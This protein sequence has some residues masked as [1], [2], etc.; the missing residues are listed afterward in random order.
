M[1][2]LLVQLKLYSY[3]VFTVQVEIWCLENT[4]LCWLSSQAIF[5]SGLMW[6]IFW[7]HYCL[8][9]IKLTGRIVRAEQSLSLLLTRARFGASSQILRTL[10]AEI[11][12]FSHEQVFKISL[13][14]EC[15]RVYLL[16]STPF[17]PRFFCFA[18]DS[19]EPV[20]KSSSFLF[21]NFSWYFFAETLHSITL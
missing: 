2:W 13:F 4:W 1:T 18:P 9:G 11:K 6:L 5:S 7:S 14:V 16:V 20:F 3:L 21:L 8:C 12:M 15:L 10:A 19:R 17:S